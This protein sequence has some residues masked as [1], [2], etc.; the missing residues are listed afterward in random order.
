MNAPSVPIPARGSFA[1]GLRTQMRVIG[2][3]ILRELHTRYGREN[4]GYLWLIGEPLMLAGVMALLHHSGHTAYGSDMKPLPFVVL[5]Y[6]TYIMFRGI[7]NR[8]DSALTSNAPLLYHRMVTIFDIVLSRALLEAAG[9]VMA[10][11]VLVTLLWSLGL[12]SL[13]ARPLYLYAADALMF[14]Y[15]LG[16]AMI[17]A[18]ITFHN[19]TIERLVHPYSYF[20]I[21]LSAAFFQVSMVPEPYRSWLL[22]LPLPHIMELARYGQFK[23]ANL[24]Y[25]SPWYVVASCMVL[26]W[27]GLV[28]MRIYRNKVHLN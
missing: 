10:Y 4:I 25:C 16:H 18:S 1:A 26:T 24:D 8:S 22:L 9:T 6:T 2:A 5:G 19:R 15:S 23:S 28:T 7:V 21:P 20:M 13:P 3:L 27:I 12:I 17:I 14:W 11:T